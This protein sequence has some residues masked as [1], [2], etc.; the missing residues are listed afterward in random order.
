LDM[1][2]HLRGRVSLSPS[3]LKA[4]LNGRTTPQIHSKPVNNYNLFGRSLTYLAYDQKCRRVGC[5]RTAADTGRKL[6]F[7]VGCRRFQY[8]SRDCQKKAWRDSKVPHRDLCSSVAILCT[9]FLMPWKHEMVRYGKH[10]HFVDTSTP[11][12]EANAEMISFVVEKLNAWS[13]CDSESYPCIEK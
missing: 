2:P 10:R 13:I 7:C 1:S 5:R 11:K 6:P 12:I 9:T 3:A 4:F 8:C